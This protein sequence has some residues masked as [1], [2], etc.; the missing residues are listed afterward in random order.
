MSNQTEE[1]KK[2]RWL[3]FLLLPAFAISTCYIMYGSRYTGGWRVLLL[4]TLLTSVITFILSATHITVAN[5]IRKR[6]ENDDKTVKRLFIS[7]CIYFPITAF[8][9]TGIFL[10]Y[11]AVHFLGYEFNVIQY[12]WGLFTGIVCDIIGM[13]MNEGIYGYSKWK[14]SKLEAEQLSKEKLQTQLNGLLQQ[15]NPHFL[16]NSLNSLSA[17]INEDTRLAQKFL[18]DLSKVYRYLLRT[19]ENELTTLAVELQFISSYFHMIETRFG[20]GVRLHQKIDEQYMTWLLPPLTLQLLLENAVKH[21][22]VSKHK[23]LTI[24]ITSEPGD[25]LVVRN[26]LQKKK[27]KVESTKLGLTNIAEKYRLINRSSINITQDENYFSVSLPLIA[28]AVTVENS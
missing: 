17:L 16:F 27:I 11:D 19:N 24:E 23:P 9:V 7:A 6:M 12:R 2:F 22:S 28:P 15:I 21:N 1:F 18:S 10:G 13:A 5:F 4:S 14:E 8:F 3:F 20:N 25:R 26:N